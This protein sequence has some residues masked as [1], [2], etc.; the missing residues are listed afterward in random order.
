MNLIRK[1][2]VIV[3]NFFGRIVEFVG[4]FGEYTYV[5]AVN[6]IVVACEFD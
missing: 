4:S 5:I 2:R 1:E 6:L 3:P